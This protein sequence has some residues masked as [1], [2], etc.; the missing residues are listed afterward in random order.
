MYWWGVG[1]KTVWRWRMAL[2]VTRTSN[3]GTR[4]LVRAASEKG[5]SRIRGKRLPPEQVER[6][7]RTALEMGLGAHLRPGYHGPWWTQEEKALLGTDT[8]EAV[9][10]RVGR[11]TQAVRIK[12]TRLGIPT[13]RDRRRR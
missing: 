9:G 7:R 10:L 13:A 4:R 12:R 6:R 11:S 3:E 1:V 8:D 2:G 5:A